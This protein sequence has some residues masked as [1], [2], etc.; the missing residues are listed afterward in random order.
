MSEFSTPWKR[1]GGSAATGR[2]N[3]HWLAELGHELSRRHGDVEVL[4]GRNKV[5][6]R[7]SDSEFSGLFGRETGGLYLY[8]RAVYREERDGGGTWWN[9]R[10]YHGLSEVPEVAAATLLETVDRSRSHF[11]RLAGEFGRLQ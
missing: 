3:A 11:H 7:F 2:P 1:G 4:P 5:V 9:D 6:L 8:L 10:R